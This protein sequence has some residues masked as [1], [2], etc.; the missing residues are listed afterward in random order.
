[1]GIFD[2]VRAA[3]QPAAVARAGYLQGQTA[4]IDKNRKQ[5][6][7]NAAI[8]RQG[9]LDQIKATLDASMIKRNNATADRAERPVAPTRPATINTDQG[10]MQW[11]PATGTYKP[12]GFKAPPKSSGVSETPHTIRTSKG[13]MMWDKDSRSFKPTGYESPPTSGTSASAQER[14]DAKTALD[15][16]E[17]LHPRPSK[18]PAQTLGTDAKGRKVIVANPAR[19]RAVADSVAYEESTMKPLRQHLLDVTVGDKVKTGGSR[20]STPAKPKYS[21]SA[22]TNRAMAEE[23]EAASADLTA[24][25]NSAAPKIVKDQARALYDRQQKAIAE[26]YGATSGSSPEDPEDDDEHRL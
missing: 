4:Q 7:E 18:V 3:V 2:L 21:Q 16:A 20:T 14:L 25:L 23:F 22:S 5:E 10:I 1:M 8:K 15:E 6:I 11:D 12:T 13:I 9:L 24:V 19:D 17:K 26:K